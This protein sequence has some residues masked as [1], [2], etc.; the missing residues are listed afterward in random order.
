MECGRLA[1]RVGGLAHND[2]LRVNPN[3]SLIA[4]DGNGLPRLDDVGPDLST[5]HR[6]DRSC[7]PVYSEGISSA[8]EAHSGLISQAGS[9]FCARL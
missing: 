7:M 2:R 3:G 8:D 4:I 5:D 1:E 6:G 9:P